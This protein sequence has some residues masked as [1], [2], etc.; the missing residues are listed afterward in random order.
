MN[1]LIWLYIAVA[2]FFLGIGVADILTW[3]GA[4]IKEYPI[5]VIVSIF[6]PVIIIIALKNIYVERR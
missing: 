5:A 2:T 3:H 6:W 1:I 4:S